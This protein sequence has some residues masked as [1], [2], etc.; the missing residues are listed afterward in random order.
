MNWSVKDW[1]RPFNRFKVNTNHYFK[2]H[3]LDLTSYWNINLHLYR[4]VIKYRYVLTAFDQYRPVLT[5]INP[6]PGQYSYWPFF[7]YDWLMVL[8][9][10]FLH[11]M[12]F[13]IQWWHSVLV[14]IH[15]H[16]NWMRDQCPRLYVPLDHGSSPCITQF[17]HVACIMCISHQFI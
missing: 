1:N 15:I 8:F 17:E 12:H 14:E 7:C 6:R 3:I 16:T 9:S 10:I 4:L 5:S 13:S 11:T 2:T